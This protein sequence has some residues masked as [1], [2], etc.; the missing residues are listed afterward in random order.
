LVVDPSFESVPG[1]VAIE[2]DRATVWSKAIATGEADMCHNLQNVEHH[3]FKFD[4]HRRPG[5]VHVHYFGACALSFGDGVELA[6]GD[7]M[8]VRFEGFGR[9][10]RNPLLVD[11]AA[12][13]LTAIRSLA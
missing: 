11:S 6:S 8:E 9:S 1:T 12:N 10:L 4:S 5:D 13:T 3:H 7:V 2:R